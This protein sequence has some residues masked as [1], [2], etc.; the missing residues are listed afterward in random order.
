MKGKIGNHRPLERVL[1]PDLVFGEASGYARMCFA[2]E[3]KLP[4][5][6]QWGG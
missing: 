1:I 2:V 3:C 6:D 5:S 4:V